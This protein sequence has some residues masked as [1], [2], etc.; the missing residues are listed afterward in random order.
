MDLLFYW[1][2]KGDFSSFLG[3]IPGFLINPTESHWYTSQGCL[4]LTSAAEMIGPDRRLAAGEKTVR[5]G[6][7]GS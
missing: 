3:G 1:G 7:G 2:T 5:L 6:C 4:N